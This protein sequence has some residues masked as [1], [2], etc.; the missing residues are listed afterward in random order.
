M[1]SAPACTFFLSSDWF[2]SLLLPLPMFQCCCQVQLAFAAEAAA[3]ERRRIEAAEAERRRQE[4]LAQ[5][6]LQDALRERE[7]SDAVAEQNR[8]RQPATAAT[9]A[10]DA[11]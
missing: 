4:E 3:E 5:Q 6:Q 8:L 7:Q 2:L 11:T 1:A 10:T 9:A